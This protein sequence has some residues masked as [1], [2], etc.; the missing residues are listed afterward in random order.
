MKKR[1]DSIAE[2][3]TS[4][5]SKSI[6]PHTPAEMEEFQEGRQEIKNLLTENRVQNTRYRYWVKNW[7]EIV[8]DRIIPSVLDKRK[9]C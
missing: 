5:M 6:D 8:D 1:K 4:K 9:S 2:A 3:F 7:Q